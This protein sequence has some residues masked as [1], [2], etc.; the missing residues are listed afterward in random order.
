M[1]SVIIGFALTLHA[2]TLSAQITVPGID[3]QLPAG[4]VNLHERISNEGQESS[5]FTIKSPWLN[6]PQIF[7]SADEYYNYLEQVVSN[8]TTLLQKTIHLITTLAQFYKSPLFNNN[9]I[10][11]D[12]FQYDS[13]FAKKF[14]PIG[15][16]WSQ[17]NRQCVD[18]NTSGL[19]DLQRVLHF[20][21][22]SLRSVDHLNHS[23]GEV[24][25]QGGW[26]N[27][28]LDPDQPGLLQK[29]P[30][31]SNGYAST[32][33]L[34][35]D[36]NLINQRYYWM[37]TNG[38]SIDLAASYS[39]HDYRV[40]FTSAVPGPFKR[41]AEPID[42]KG[43]II[44]C[45]NCELDFSLNTPYVLDTSNVDGK[46]A[47][48]KGLAWYDSLTIT[49]QQR[50]YDSILYSISNYFR[51]DYSLA[52]DVLENMSIGKPLFFRTSKLPLCTLSIP[53]STELLEIGKDVK[54]P[55]LVTDIAQAGQM[56]LG[57]STI[58]GEFAPLLWIKNND[59]LILGPINPLSRTD[60]EVSY[61][62]RG[63]IY[64]HTDTIKVTMAYNPM[65]INI[66]KGFVIDELGEND[67]LEIINDFTDTTISSINTP[68]A[69][70][71][72]AIGPN[73]VNAR[74]T[75]T[76][77]NVGPNAQPVWFDISGR[78]MAVTYVIKGND[79]HFQLG[80]PGM[81][82][83]KIGSKV[84]KITAF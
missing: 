5:I 64:P 32:A 54:L 48:Q 3:G 69:D 80:E 40:L 9:Y 13:V 56:V 39:M 44:L 75:A 37:D 12:H 2:V 22:D 51:M 8:D 76:I 7:Y 72:L 47:Y 60:N 57:D 45:K 52:T 82:I 55:F 14:S 34:K 81:Y 20:P 23:T 58:R 28:D 33:D 65:L 71:Y 61:F 66:A 1:K 4:Q 43:E 10:I 36:T 16:F 26:I 11:F 53:P 41:L 31:S 79:I 63:Y 15:T 35:A 74:Q 83:V 78:K 59:S 42:L 77:Y 67:T 24:F 19:L 49:G 70:D 30:S 17:Y 21:Q 84:A 25:V 68:S 46:I 38:D 50:Y 29:M 73:P 27:F 62:D 18:Y 6:Q